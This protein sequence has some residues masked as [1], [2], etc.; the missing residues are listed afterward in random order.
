MPEDSDIYFGVEIE[1][2]VKMDR[3][4]VGELDNTDHFEPFCDAQSQIFINQLKPK[5]DSQ[6]FFTDDD[7][8]QWQ[9][10]RDPSIEDGGA[11]KPSDFAVPLEI[12][13]RQSELHDV[14][15][16][17]GSEIFTAY[18]KFFK[19][20]ST[21]VHFSFPEQNAT[22]KLLDFPV[23]KARLL[24]L[25]AQVFEKAIDDLMPGGWRNRKY[26]GSLQT[27]GSNE[28]ESE[29]EEGKPKPKKVDNLCEFWHRMERC[30]TMAQLAGTVNFT[31]GYE[32]EPKRKRGD[33]RYFKWNCFSHR[34]TIHYR[35]VE[36]RQMPPA[37]SPE[38][39]ELWIRF[40]AGFVRAAVAVDARRIDAAAAMGVDDMVRELYVGDKSYTS[41]AAD[42]EAMGLDDMV[43]EMHV[44]DRCT[45]P[46]DGEALR[47]FIGDKVPAENG[48][49]DELANI[50]EKM[51]LFFCA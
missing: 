19:N 27:P 50:K 35:T 20:C 7:Y 36:F 38:D 48:F 25:A 6:L 31:E 46:A 24:F 39:V 14:W 44:G 11:I 51:N 23:K 34:P 8:R 5:L 40:V 15:S 4:L 30:E 37:L 28:S 10:F 47:A 22:N 18:P 2:V 33:A 43:R 16:V 41:T 9:F 32:E 3:G 26:A 17:I 45:A 21:H 42:R 12:K 1:T 13:S 49:W 29:S